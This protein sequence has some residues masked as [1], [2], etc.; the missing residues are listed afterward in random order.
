MDDMELACRGTHGMRPGADA[1]QIV[2]AHGVRPGGADAVR[3]YAPCH[4]WGP[5][6]TKN[7]K[8]WRTRPKKLLTSMIITI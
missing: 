7:V 1:G 5:Q 8:P 2:G 3:P 4:Y 6:T